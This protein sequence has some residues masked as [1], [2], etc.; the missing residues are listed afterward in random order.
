[1]KRVVE[2]D[3]IFEQGGCQVRVRY[4]EDFAESAYTQSVDLGYKGGF[5]CLPEGRMRDLIDV[6][7]AGLEEL[8]KTKNEA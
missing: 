4:R 2:R 8:E 3:T 1:M 6:L 5:F 7:N